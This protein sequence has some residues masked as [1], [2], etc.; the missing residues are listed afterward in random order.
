MNE[1]KTIAIVQARMGEADFRGRALQPILDRPMLDWVIQRTRRSS[2][3]AEVIV[4]T[5]LDTVD[6]PIEFWC[7]Q[8]GVRF[9]RAPGKDVLDRYVRTAAWVNADHVVRISGDCPLIDHELIDAVVGQFH[10]DPTCDWCS[11]YWPEK[12]YPAGLEV[13]CFSL[14]ALRRIN[15]LA[16][17]PQLREHLTLAIYRQPSAFRISSVCAAEDYSW[18]NWRV[19]TPGDLELVRAIADWFEHDNFSWRT[20]AELCRRNWQWSRFFSGQQQRRAA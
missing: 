9:F 12:N 14:D 13:D 7:A 18:L 20:A 15:D 19:R 8:R 5:S 10:A 4:A 16:D 2:R 3:I 17:T 11:N 6:D 1:K